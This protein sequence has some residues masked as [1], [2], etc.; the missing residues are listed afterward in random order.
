MKLVIQTIKPLP[1]WSPT[2]LYSMTYYI[3]VDNINGNLY[4][5]KKKMSEEN[6]LNDN[7]M[8]ME[9]L[10]MKTKKAFGENGML[11]EAGRSVNP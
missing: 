5:S 3:G 9:A 8:L 1:P 7:L 6:L 2:K 11:D 10:K 4:K